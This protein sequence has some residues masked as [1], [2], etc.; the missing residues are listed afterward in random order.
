MDEDGSAPL[1]VKGGK[2]FTQMHM[3]KN[4]LNYD[5]NAIRTHFKG[6]HSGR[7]RRLG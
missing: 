5:S 2:W 6:A 4:I 7:V 3:G 1:P